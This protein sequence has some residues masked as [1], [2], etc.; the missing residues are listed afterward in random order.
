MILRLGHPDFSSRIPADRVT[1]GVNNIYHAFTRRGGVV[2]WTAR[3]PS[4][5]IAPQLR[6]FPALGSFP[7]IA[8]VPHAPRHLERSDNASHYPP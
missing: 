1:I 2:K 8:F 4:V 7:T 6:H 5:V 3:R